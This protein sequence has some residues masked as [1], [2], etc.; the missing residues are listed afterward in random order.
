MHR[1]D[2]VEDQVREVQAL[3]SAWE[4][5]GVPAEDSEA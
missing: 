3:D 5:R 4:V 1:S 2:R